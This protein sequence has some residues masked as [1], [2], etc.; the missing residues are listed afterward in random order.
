[1]KN[2]IEW[3]QGN[4]GELRPALATGEMLALDVSTVREQPAAIAEPTEP[5]S[6]AVEVQAIDGAI[7]TKEQPLEL[8]SPSGEITPLARAGEQVTLGPLLET[9]LWTVR[10]AR[11]ADQRPSLTPTS[12]KSAGDESAGEGDILVACNLVDPAESDLRPR[13]ELAA[14]PS[15]GLALLGGQSL[16]FYLTLVAALLIAAEWWLYQR[17]IVG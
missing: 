4:T 12:T 10:P 9:G 13:G 15:R 11:P 7:A 3:F 5:A 2:T 8:V 1:M 6:E 16:W 17:R 14:V